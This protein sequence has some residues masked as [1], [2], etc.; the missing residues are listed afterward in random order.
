M[1]NQEPVIGLGTFLS[2]LPRK[3][4]VHVSEDWISFQTRDCRREVC[5]TS[6]T[7]EH[8]LRDTFNVLDLE[9]IGPRPDFQYHGDLQLILQSFRGL[10]IMQVLRG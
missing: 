9:H 7:E 3:S 5:L 2:W 1:R 4:A 10:K 6:L 8:M